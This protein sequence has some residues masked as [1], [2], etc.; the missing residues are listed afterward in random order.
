[1]H[2]AMVAMVVFGLVVSLGC[3][4]GSGDEQENDG[5]GDG[6]NKRKDCDDFDDSVFPGQDEIPY[7]G[8]D[9]DCDGLDLTDLDQDGFD[10]WEVDG[11]DCDD[12]DPNVHPDSEE[13]YYDRVDN[14]CNPDTNDLDADQDGWTL[15]EDCDD[16]DIGRS[17]DE[18]EICDGL[19]QDCD[20]VVDDDLY[21]PNDSLDGARHVGDNNQQLFIE[22]W[23]VNGDTVDVFSVWAADDAD[24][25]VNEFYVLAE[26]DAPPDVNSFTLALYDAAGTRLSFDDDP[27]DGLS[28]AFNAPSLSSGYSGEYYIE[29]TA[30]GTPECG[31]YDLRID[32]GS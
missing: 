3:F 9:Q 31:V 23:F 4:G 21:E 11:E 17:P 20:G 15:L 32:N 7:D 29:V 12:K 16:A 13:I 14:D 5:D 18:P 2:K 26:I 6:V 25:I 30:S 28:V 22:A 8:V 19:D 10:S 1:M 27:S 24:F